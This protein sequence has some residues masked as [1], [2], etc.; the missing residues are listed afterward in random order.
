MLA[1]A[2]HYIWMEA[3]KVTRSLLRAQKFKQLKS[4]FD[5][6]M[7]VKL[8]KNIKQW[9]LENWWNAKIQLQKTN[10]KFQTGKVESAKYKILLFIKS[11]IEIYGMNNVTHL[12]CFANVNTTSR[13]FLEC[14]PE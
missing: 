1:K 13:I 7:K 9:W 10:S 5:K 2:H 4:N 12:C 6:K 11:W 14:W 8:R 3:M